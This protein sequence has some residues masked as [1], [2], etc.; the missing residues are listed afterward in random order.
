M[1][2]VRCLSIS[3]FASAFCV[4]PVKAQLDISLIS[5][6]LYTLELKPSPKTFYLAKS[7]F[8]PETYDDLGLSEYKRS[9]YD[10]NQGNNCV[11][12]ALSSCPDNGLCSRCPFNGS[13]LRLTHCKS[14]FSKKDNA[15]IPNN[16]YA[17]NSTYKEAIPAD[18]ICIK[19]VQYSLTCYK[20]CRPVNCSDYP[21]SCADTIPNSISLQP[22]PDCADANANCTASKCKISKCLDGYKIADNGKECILLDDTCSNGYY[23]DCQ[24]GTTGE[25]QFTE[26]GTACYKCQA[27]T[28][29]NGSYNLNIYWCNSALKCL[30]PAN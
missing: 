3:L 5:H 15:C 2:S 17:I 11:G 23:K 26:K 22:C 28:C 27:R 30:L 8:L 4:A 13:L 20:D 10:Y 25:P 21:L 7:T 9:K 29:S 24:T 12:Y 1:F 14:G 18:S 16:C 19:T 6:N